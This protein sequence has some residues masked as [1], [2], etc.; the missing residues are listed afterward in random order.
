MNLTILGKT[1]TSITKSKDDDKIEMVTDDN[2]YYRMQ[3]YQDCC[4]SVYVESI[5]GDLNDLIGSP[6]L[7]AEERCEEDTK[8]CESGT[9]KFLYS[10][11][12]YSG[13]RNMPCS[14][15]QSEQ[16]QLLRQ[17]F[18]SYSGVR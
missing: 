10:S 9:W 6:I 14:F 8:A 2:R 1:L 15:P 7:R 13:Y 11:I 5:V 12:S 4:E 18:G 3:H 16:R 17:S